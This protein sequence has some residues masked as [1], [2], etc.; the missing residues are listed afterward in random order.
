[1]SFKLK[2]TT[3]N[4]SKGRRGDGKKGEEMGGEGGEVMGGARRGG[5][6]GG[7]EKR[8]SPKNHDNFTIIFIGLRIHI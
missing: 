2:N 3:F 5:R 4:Y 1:M 7:R 8:R 6:R